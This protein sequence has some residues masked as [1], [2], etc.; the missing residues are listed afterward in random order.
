MKKL[1]YFILC[2]FMAFEIQALTPYEATY[3]LSVTSDL[4]KFKIGN[5]RFILVTDNN[6]EFTFSSTAFTDSIWKSFHDYSRY[7]LHLLVFPHDCQ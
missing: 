4:G 6:D 7:V 2:F 5:A 3:S 1:F